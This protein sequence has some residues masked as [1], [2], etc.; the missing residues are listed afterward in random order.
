M[1]PLSTK[2]VDTNHLSA[3]QKADS[4]EKVPRKKKD[5]QDDELPIV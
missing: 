1:A 4:S 5:S 2:K 3:D